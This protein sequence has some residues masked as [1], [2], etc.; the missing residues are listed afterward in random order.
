MK[1]FWGLKRAIES[2]DTNAIKSGTME[3]LKKEF[4]LQKTTEDFFNSSSGIGKP[5][6]IHSDGQT[7]QIIRI[8]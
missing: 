6:D 4:I 8:Q 3:D 2:D 1:F 5:V 7:Y